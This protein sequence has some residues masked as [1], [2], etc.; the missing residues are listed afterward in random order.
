[1][2]AKL[3]ALS[4]MALVMALHGP[5]SH[6][7]G[8]QTCDGYFDASQKM[9][10]ILQKAFDAIN[11]KNAADQAAVLPAIE[12][13][14]NKLAAVEVKPEVC[15]GNHINAYTQHQFL[16]L[17]TLRAKGVDIGF[18]ANLPIVKQPNLNQGSLAY[19]V[20]WIKFERGD[21]NAALPAYEKGL[22][23]FP[24]DHNLQNEY[25]ATL[26]RL[27]RYKDTIAFSDKILA[28]TY[29]FDDETRSKILFAR[30]I[31]FY[32]D[33]QLDDAK[34]ALKVAKRYNDTDEI[35]AEIKLVDDALAK[36]KP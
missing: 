13:E 35:D 28:N 30:G 4:T 22:A 27:Q 2:H 25:L 20:G 14:L 16:E 33:N 3:L 31:A 26:I 36:K 32:S 24:H 8:S 15:N 5:A 10:S 12:S 18:P 23:M 34:E 1:M 9:S 19:A 21:F 6:A 7:Q 29:D 11:A 17:S